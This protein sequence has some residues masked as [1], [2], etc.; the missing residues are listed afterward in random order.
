MLREVQSHVFRSGGAGW[1]GRWLITRMK[2]NYINSPPHLVANLLHPVLFPAR[3][4]ISQGS[5]MDG[6]MAQ[7]PCLQSAPSPPIATRDSDT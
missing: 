3:Y 4:T 1:R 7:H 6:T 2:H 5:R